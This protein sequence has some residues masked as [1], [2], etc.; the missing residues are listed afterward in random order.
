ML[1]GISRRSLSLDLDGEETRSG[2]RA[3]ASLKADAKREVS[4]SSPT[5]ESSIAVLG[6]ADWVRQIPCGTNTTRHKQA[7][8]GIRD[9]GVIRTLSS[10]WRPDAA[11]DCLLDEI[12]CARRNDGAGNHDHD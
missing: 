3:I 5:T 4:P 2:D 1:V 10:P 11:S 8:T 7:N 12:R 9:P 6:P